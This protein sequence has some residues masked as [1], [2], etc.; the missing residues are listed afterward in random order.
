MLLQSR[1]HRNAQT[2]LWGR[3]P[4][5]AHDVVVKTEQIDGKATVDTPASRYHGGRLQQDRGYPGHLAWRQFEQRLERV[6]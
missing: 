2:A 4:Q 3:T 5:H 1:L 6:P